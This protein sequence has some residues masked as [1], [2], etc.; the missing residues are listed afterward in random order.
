MVQ[1]TRRIVEHIETER[2]K[3]GQNLDEFETKI[4][5]AQTRIRDATSPKVWFDR[6]P[7]AVLGAAAVTGLLFAMLLPKKAARS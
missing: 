5:D 1:E 3:L 6:K 2:A 4:R 7:A